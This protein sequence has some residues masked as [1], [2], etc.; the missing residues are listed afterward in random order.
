VFDLG[1]KQRIGEMIGQGQAGG[2]SGFRVSGAEGV[3]CTR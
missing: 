3:I 2:W 1:A